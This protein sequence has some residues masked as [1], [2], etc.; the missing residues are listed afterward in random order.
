M[1]DLGQWFAE[2]YT[3]PEDVDAEAPDRPGPDPQ[4]RQ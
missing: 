1:S 4:P 3:I 2:R